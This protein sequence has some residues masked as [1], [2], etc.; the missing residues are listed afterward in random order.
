MTNTGWGVCCKQVSLGKEQKEI[1][2]VSKHEF[3]EGLNCLACPCAW[4]P[5]ALGSSA[6]GDGVLSYPG[7]EKLR[8]GKGPGTC[9]CPALAR[10]AE[11]CTL[12]EDGFY[13]LRQPP[14]SRHCIKPSLGVLSCF[15]IGNRRLA[16]LPGESL[17]KFPLTPAARGWDPESVILFS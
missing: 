11:P 6:P 10:C 1:E 5:A 8:R 4:H 16:P 7:W 2:F 17:A 12:P 15:P 9:W 3:S 13:P 14:Q